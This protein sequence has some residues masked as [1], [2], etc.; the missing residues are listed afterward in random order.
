MLK[1]ILI[2]ISICLVLLIV[3]TYIFTEQTLKYNQNDYET[4]IALVK[5]RL[6]IESELNTVYTY[7]LTNKDRVRLYTMD[8]KL[9]FAL[10]V[11]DNEDFILY[12]VKEYSLKEDNILEYQYEKNDNLVNICFGFNKTHN[13]IIFKQKD[14]VEGLETKK[15]LAKDTYIV[16]PFYS[17]EEGIIT[18]E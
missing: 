11:R 14:T 18:I 17:K 1:K 13:Y 7:D 4:E 3:F 6:S 16:I 5:K 8:D 15:L 10:A 12:D 2:G 9:I